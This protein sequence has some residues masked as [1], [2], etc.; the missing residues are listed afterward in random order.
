VRDLCQVTD[1]LVLARQ[2]HP[3]E[4][5]NLD[6]LCNRYGIDNSHPGLQGALL[7]AQILADVYLAM[8]SGSH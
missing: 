7:D 2:W 6:V 4:R 3:G 1:T 5:N 8:T